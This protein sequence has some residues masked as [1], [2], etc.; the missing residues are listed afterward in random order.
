MTRGIWIIYFCVIT[1][2][3]RFYDKEMDNIGECVL[4]HP[5]NP[6]LITLTKVWWS[7]VGN[8]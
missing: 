1:P 6:K 3:P 4:F 7:L 8:S 5:N 2:D